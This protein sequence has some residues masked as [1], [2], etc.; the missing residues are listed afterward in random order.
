[1]TDSAS[2]VNTDIPETPAEAP[3]EAPVDEPTDLGTDFSTEEQP[4]DSGV[5]T[6]TDAPAEEP[7]NGDTEENPDEPILKTVQKLT[8]KLSQKMRDGGEELTSKDYKYVINSIVSAIDMTKI[9]EEDM[10]D[11]LNKVQNKDSEDT[12]T[13]EVPQEQPVQEQP[14]DYLQ[15]IQ[16]S[17][18]DEFLNK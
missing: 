8:G 11:I 4:V 3:I 7:A 9:S 10:K 1:M 6:T 2:S 5:D 14:K 18:I 13:Q 15:R 12:S 17:M 16:K